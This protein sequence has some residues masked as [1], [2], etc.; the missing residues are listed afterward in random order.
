MVLYGY[1]SYT[2][3]LMLRLSKLTDYG[4]VVMT[5]L[6][7]EPDR[8]HAANEV[9]TGT[10]VALPTVSKLLKHLSR[11]D[12]V[13]SV[14]GAKGGYRLA[15]DAGDISVAQVVDVLE[16]PVALTECSTDT[17]NCSQASVCS[18]RVNFQRING[19]IRGALDG[20]SLAE[21]VGP[22]DAHLVDMSGLRMPKRAEAC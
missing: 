9:A 16:G 18:I 13:L 14:R 3:L 6:A 8:L 15:R 2:E 22:E 10:Q 12:L 17:G 1:W 7:R 4:I 5:Y 21:L 20:V 19:A 11:G